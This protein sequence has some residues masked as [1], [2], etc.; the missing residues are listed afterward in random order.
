[1]REVRDDVYSFLVARRAVARAALHLGVQEMSH[2][3]LDTLADVLLAYL[4]RFG[5]RLADAVESS[6]R[7]SAHTNALDALHAVELCTSA[8]VQRT[9]APN[10]STLGS[11]SDAGLVNG[12][13]GNKGAQTTPFVSKTDP[14]QDM[15]WKGLAAFCFGP[16]WYRQSMQQQ[17]EVSG[18]KGRS[19]NEAVSN[20]VGGKVGPSALESG[21]GTVEEEASKRLAGWNAPFPDEI[22]RFP[23]SILADEKQ[24]A[25]ANSADGSDTQG[26]DAPEKQVFD[27]PTIKDLPDGLFSQTWGSLRKQE[28]TESAGASVP[29]AA[30]KR[31]HDQTTRKEEERPTK[32]V[33]LNSNASAVPPRPERETAAE[34][35]PDFYPAFP[36][37]TDSIGRTVVELEETDRSGGKPKATSQRLTSRGAGGLVS[38]DHH[39][40]VRSAL[41]N[42]D[43]KDSYWGS[44][45]DRTV[46]KIKVPA[47]QPEGEAS[48]VKPQIQ[49][50][51]KAS[52]SLVSRVLEGSMDTTTLP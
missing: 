15:S 39:D 8:A 25:L 45:W 23:L 46:E 4:E 35:V 14:V 3:A 43:Q 44:S 38:S 51:G 40:R 12:D 17:T 47:G 31:K 24:A 37:P 22:P 32:R 18:G 21:D 41:V 19:S 20:A 1:M 30:I 48:P 6:G 42:I 29:P 27:D 5:K 7:S 52:S 49:P 26:S 2:E 36:N 13:D 34:Y 9:H 11:V 33:R 10:A 28:A 50:V 16:D